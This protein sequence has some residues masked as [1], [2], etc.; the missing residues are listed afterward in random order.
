MRAG[1]TSP[2]RRFHA[3]LRT[4]IPGHTIHLGDSQQPARWTLDDPTFKPQAVPR[5]EGQKPTVGLSSSLR[6]LCASQERCPNVGVVTVAGR[7]IPAAVPLTPHE[8]RGGGNLKRFCEN[9]RRRPPPPPSPPYRNH[10][11]PPS[12]FLFAAAAADDSTVAAPVRGVDDEDDDDEGDDDDK[13]LTPE[14]ILRRHQLEGGAAI[15]DSPPSAPAAPA[16]G[17]IR[18]VAS[19]GCSRCGGTACGRAGGR[20]WMAAPN[21]VGLRII[22]TDVND[23]GDILKEGFPELILSRSNS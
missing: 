10:L 22:R 1:P 2:L 3:D 14:E 5:M 23:C 18:I 16:H 12:S 6:R 9:H 20:G 4:G 21:S 19:S 15:P 8:L 17:Q 11:S 7:S 13:P